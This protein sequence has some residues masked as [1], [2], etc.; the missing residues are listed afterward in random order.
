[1]SDIPVVAVTI[2]HENLDKEAVLA[3]AE[4]ITKATGLPACDALSEGADLV[5][6]A[7]KPY[8]KRLKRE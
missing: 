7:L 4:E 8:L 5:V 3:A 1:L 2:N 6:S